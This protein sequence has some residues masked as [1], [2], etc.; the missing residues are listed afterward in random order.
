[1]VS[2]QRERELVETFVD[3]ADTLVVGYDIVDLLYVLVNRCARTLDAADAGILLPN[4][5]DQLEVPRSHQKARR[6]VLA[7]V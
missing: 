7:A 3:L 2:V 4:D 6:N 1:M 5:Q